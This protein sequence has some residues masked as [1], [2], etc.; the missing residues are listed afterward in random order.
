M[1]AAACGGLNEQSR[2]II[3]SP[4]TIEQLRQT[5]REARTA[6]EDAV[7]AVKAANEEVTRTHSIWLAAS[8]A[9]LEAERHGKGSKSKK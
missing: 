9:L 8:Q 5:E 2:E 4:L 6:W 3:V 7:K 1:L